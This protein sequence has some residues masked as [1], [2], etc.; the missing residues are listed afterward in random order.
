MA[1]PK[2]SKTLKDNKPLLNNDVL[3][4][5]FYAARLA[6]MSGPNH[7]ALRGPINQLLLDTNLLLIKDDHFKQ[8]LHTIPEFALAIIELM[9]SPFNQSYVHACQL[10]RPELCMVCGSDSYEFAETR[11]FVYPE[12]Y[13]GDSAE[14]SMLLGTC[15]DCFKARELAQKGG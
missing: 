8:E 11:L 5:V 4:D 6:Y 13:P 1:V 2:A 3:D 14:P 9:S 12:I 7:E 15:T 10:A